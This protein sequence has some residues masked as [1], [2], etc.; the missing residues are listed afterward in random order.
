[1][2]ASYSLLGLS[3]AHSTITYSFATSTLDA[4]LSRPFSGFMTGAYQ[5]AVRQAI[6][7]WES[8][9]GLRLVEVPDAADVDIRL[10]WG[11]LSAGNGGAVIG[12]TAFP[13]QKVFGDLVPD[14][15]LRVIDPLLGSLVAGGDG[16]YYFANF[17][18]PTLE[19]I[20]AHE[21]GHA[22]GLDHSAQPT[23]LMY[24]VA[25]TSNPVISAFDTEGI[26]FLYGHPFAGTASVPAS[27]GPMQVGFDNAARASLAQSLIDG[28][29]GLSRDV[30]AAGSFS[31]ATTQRN[32]ASDAVGPITLLMA[33]A[34]AGGRSIIVGTG[35]L[36]TSATGS[37]T[38]V[39]G[40][41]A[42]SIGLPLG[43]AGDWRVVLGDGDDTVQ[44]QAGDD[45]IEPGG[46]A[47]LV[48]L[49][50]G[51]S[52]V[53][54]TGADTIVGGTGAATIRA[55]AGNA[56]A[57]SAGAP[58]LFFADAGADT[59]IGNNG[60]VTV[61]GGPG[62]G[63]F[64]GG[65]LGG[66]AITAGA[67]AATILGAGPGDLLYAAGSGGDLVAGGTGS[68]TISAEASLGNDTLFAGTGDTLLRGGY[69][70]DILV[71]ATGNDTIQP[72][73]GAELIAFIAGRSGGIDRVDGFIPG[74]TSILLSGYGPTAVTTALAGATTSP[75]GL[76]LSLPDGTTILFAGL[77]SLTPANFL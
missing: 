32:F 1:M 9:A 6:H 58:L 65:S 17:G 22:L 42:N 74:T 76:T 71:P 37:G 25:T 50:T 53:T 57:F 24:P 75:A 12:L 70:L 77:S 34:P 10:G 51:A 60:Q 69:G 8:Y 40:G 55:T 56:L 19:Q 68:G 38:I 49:G 3:W 15:L 64:T 7:T 63:V 45:V 43:Y 46:G 35:G 72:G 36:T 67:G 13:H 30:R 27:D 4:D 66:N 29:S 23:A 59:V 52:S 41:G 44:A 39:A 11:A 62:G 48:F 5:V 26:Q 21:M 61:V 33:G 14:V 18:F 54:T 31:L 2:A 16:H 20:A 47:N 28:R 73:P